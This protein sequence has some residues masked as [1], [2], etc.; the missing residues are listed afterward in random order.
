MCGNDGVRTEPMTLRTDIAKI[1]AVLILLTSLSIEAR[2][3]FQLD[4]P[5]LHV[6]ALELRGITSL[7][8][9]PLPSSLSLH[10]T[11]DLSSRVPSYSR[12]RFRT[13]TADSKGSFTFGKVPVGDYWIVMRSPSAEHVHV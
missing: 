1:L 4:S 6:S 7:N 12:K 8:G 3:C 2:A 9:R 11:V 5:V 13:A 10:K